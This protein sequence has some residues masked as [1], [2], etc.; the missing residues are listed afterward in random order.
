MEREREKKR[1]IHS[2]LTNQRE[3]EEGWGGILKGSQGQSAKVKERYRNEGRWTI[4][5]R[6]RRYGRK[7]CAPLNWVKIQ[8]T[9][10]WVFRPAHF[11]RSPLCFPPQTPTTSCPPWVL[12]MNPRVRPRLQK[13]PKAT[14]ANF[15][16]LTRRDGEKKIPKVYDRAARIRRS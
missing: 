7:Q 2:R 4:D 1:D 5:R 14:P 10:L 12:R 9:T 3:R 16:L 8:Q 6:R 13:N 15:K 11:Y